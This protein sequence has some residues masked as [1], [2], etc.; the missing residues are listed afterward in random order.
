MIMS[1]FVR[2]PLIIHSKPHHFPPHFVGLAS[3]YHVVVVV[4]F[5]LIYF[6]A[7][8]KMHSVY[9]PILLCTSAYLLTMKNS[10]KDLLRCRHIKALGIY[11]LSIVTRIKIHVIIRSDQPFF[12]E[13]IF[14]LAVSIFFLRVFT[15]RIF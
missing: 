14:M 8:D 11:V 15:T 5:M 9:L 1:V 4:G 12:T 2:I 7:M 10:Q 3:E 13:V 6:L